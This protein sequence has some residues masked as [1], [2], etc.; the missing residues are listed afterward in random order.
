MPKVIPRV[1]GGSRSRAQGCVISTPL[2]SKLVFLNGAAKVTQLARM[3]WV[4]VPPRDFCSP[5]LGVGAGGP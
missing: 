3:G 2:I 5:L 1:S 4:P